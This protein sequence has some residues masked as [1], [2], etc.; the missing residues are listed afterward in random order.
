MVNKMSMC[1]W[2]YCCTLISSC[3]TTTILKAPAAFNYVY[4][5]DTLLYDDKCEQ[6][7]FYKVRKKAK[8]VKLRTWYITKNQCSDTAYVHDSFHRSRKYHLQDSIRYHILEGEVLG[9][10]LKELFGSLE[11]RRVYYLKTIKSEGVLQDVYFSYQGDSMV[12]N[13]DGPVEY[14]AKLTWFS[15][16]SGTGIPLSRTQFGILANDLSFHL[17]RLQ[18]R[19]RPESVTVIID[20]YE[21]MSRQELDF[22]LRGRIMK[23]VKDRIYQD[24]A[25]FLWSR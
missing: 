23:S 22:L 3:K 16:L 8:S 10:S 19:E 11:Q 5:A 13:V 4:G 17:S 7:Y 1:F 12:V 9:M 15:F 2:V 21:R 18:F 6:Y 14:H 25:I 24:L 20:E